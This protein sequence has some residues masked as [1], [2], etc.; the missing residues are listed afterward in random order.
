M[1][2]ENATLTA[3]DGTALTTY[4]WIPNI[5]KVRGNIIIVHGYGEYAGRYQHVA[6]YFTEQGYAVYAADLRGHGRSRG[7]EPGYFRSFDTLRH[8]LHE[9]VEWARDHHPQ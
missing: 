9:V 6:T 5:E 1:E 7:D 4:S 8:D 2:Y 3:S